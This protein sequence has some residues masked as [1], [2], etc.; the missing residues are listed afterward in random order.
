MISKVKASAATRA[1]MSVQFT[2]SRSMALAIRVVRGQIDRANAA[3][4]AR[5]HRLEKSRERHA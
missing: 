3:D 1:D 5:R 2:I 4:V